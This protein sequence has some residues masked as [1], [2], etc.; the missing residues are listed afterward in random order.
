M[1]MLYLP[2]KGFVIQHMP[3]LGLGL[4]FLQ[5][6]Q[7]IDATKEALVS[8]LIPLS[9]RK[10]AG[11]TQGLPPAGLNTWPPPRSAYFIGRCYM[12]S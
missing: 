12:V 4:H 1:Y 11:S 2:R 8:E 5:V 6:H 9:P 7:G 3:T 10:I